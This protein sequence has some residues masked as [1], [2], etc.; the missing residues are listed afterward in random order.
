VQFKLTQK[1]LGFFDRQMK[2]TVEPGEFRVRLSNSSV[3]G[4]LGTFRVTP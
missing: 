2:W 4:L 1:H 3:G